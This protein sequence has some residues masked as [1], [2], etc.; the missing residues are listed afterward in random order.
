MKCGA[1]PTGGGTADALHALDWACRSGRWR[2]CGSS[3]SKTA[4]DFRHD[5]WPSVKACSG[6]LGDAAMDIEIGRLLTMKAAWQALDT[7]AR[8]PAKRSR[9]PRSGVADVLHKADRH[10]DPAE[11]GARAIRRTSRAG[12][13]VP[14]RAAR[15]SWSTA[16]PRFTRWSSPAICWPMAWISGA[17]ADRSCPMALSRGV[18]PNLRP[19]TG[20]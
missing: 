18:N 20:T 1:D 8:A 9:W 16:R 13:D 15:R 6:L 5:S 17:G 3:M 7:G 12:M 11:R 4:R 14:L 2:N 10:G 19:I